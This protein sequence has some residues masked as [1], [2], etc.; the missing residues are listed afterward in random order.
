MVFH[1]LHD[2]RELTGISIE[3]KYKEDIRCPHVDQHAYP[4][5]VNKYLWSPCRVLSYD[6]NNTNRPCQHG[7]F[8][9]W[10]ESQKTTR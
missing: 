8:L 6:G 3:M 9:K 1:Y 2:K 5:P 7:T 4:S 10:A